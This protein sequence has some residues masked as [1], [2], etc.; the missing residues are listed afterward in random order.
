MEK[1]E[2]V[3]PEKKT[4]DSMEPI[5][6]TEADLSDY[7]GKPPFT[8]DRLY[9]G[10]LPPGTVTGL[11]WTAMGGAVLY[12]EANALPRQSH[13]NAGEG[14]GEAAS[15]A[16]RIPPSLAVTGQLGGVMKESSQIALLLA[17]KQLTERASKNGASFSPTFFEEHELYLHCPEGATPKDGPSAGVTMTTA[18]LSLATGRATLADLAMTGEVSLNGKVLAVGGIKEKTIAA[19]RAGCKTLVFPQA[20]RRDFEELPDYLREGLDVHFASHYDEVF[21][22]A[23]P[24]A[25]TP[26]A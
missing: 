10:Q 23:F 5:K 24:E 13:Q 6:V 2:E 9:E 11:A 18:L 1:H 15:R 17:R 21:S 12:V 22:V 16:P 3:E 14:S 19:R 7:V 4:E 8:S 26:P 25:T 20:N